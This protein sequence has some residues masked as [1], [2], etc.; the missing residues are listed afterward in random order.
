[1]AYI[2]DQ[3]RNTFIDDE[4]KSLGNKLALIDNDELEKAIKQIDEQFGP[5]TVFPASELPPKEN[6]YK[7]FEDR[8]L[9]TGIEDE[10]RE[11]YLKYLED[12]PENAKGG[13]N[14]IIQLKDF[15]PAFIKENAADGGLM[16]Q[17]F[18]DDPTS[19][20]GTPRLK[21]A[22]PLLAPALLPY[23][24]TFIGTAATGLGL[25][26][27]V[28]NYFE[29]NPDA[30]DKFKDYVSRSIGYTGEGQVFGPDDKDKKGKLK[31]RG[32]LLLK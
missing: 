13:K 23:A 6:P 26:R 21:A 1:L 17:N 3:E 32:S 19:N 15:A 28:Q 4:D 12:R 2:F 9:M 11:Y 7:E 10:T 16:R 30:I 20:I 27:K 14:K 29:N 24:A 18:A 22:F 5:G 31:V 25:Q 8:N